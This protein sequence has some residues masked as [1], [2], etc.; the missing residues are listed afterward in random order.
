MI[1]LSTSFY[2]LKDTK[3][4]EVIDLINKENFDIDGVELSSNHI[5]E[6]NFEKILK[7][8][9][10]K[11]IINHNYFPPK[12]NSNDFVVNLASSNKKIRLDSISFIKDSINFCS[13]NNINIYTIHPGFKSDPKPNIGLNNNYD[14]YFSKVKTDYITAFENFLNSLFEILEYS[15][16]KNVKICIETMGSR[17]SSENL[18]L[19]KPQEFDELL[20]ISQNYDI[21]FNLNLAHSY[22]SSIQFSFN[23]KE[24]IEKIFE[25]IILVE[26]SD[27]DRFYDQHLPLKKN[28]YVFEYLKFIKDKNLILELRN[29]SC[30]DVH[31]S[32]E[33][34]RS[35][36]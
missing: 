15:K 26:I 33:I 9:N 3:F 35:S 12:K 34:L 1:F 13:N 36:I 23:L 27:N 19:Q 10:N 31:A 21:F 4:S 22:L 11:K 14:F 28:S 24:L 7:T 25:N 20:N 8:L 17:T 18:I 2:G 5:Y 30:I 6:N 29:T 32:L 16:N